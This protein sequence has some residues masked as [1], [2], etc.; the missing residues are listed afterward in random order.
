MKKTTFTAAVTTFSLSDLPSGDRAKRE[1]QII[2]RALAL[3]T[4]RH[5]QRQKSKSKHLD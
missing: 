4:K 3:W 1:D 2:Q 5:Q